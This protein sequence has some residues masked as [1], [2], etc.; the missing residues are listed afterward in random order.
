MRNFIDFD[1]RT[2]GIKVDVFE[3]KEI[4][5]LYQLIISQDPS[6]NDED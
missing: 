4:T 2:G 6:F 3:V 5:G 1:G